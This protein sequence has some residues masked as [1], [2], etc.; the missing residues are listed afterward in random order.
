MGTTIEEL[1]R[2][3]LGEVG[4]GVGLGRKHVVGTFIGTFVS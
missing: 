2:F 3:V 4:S 1:I